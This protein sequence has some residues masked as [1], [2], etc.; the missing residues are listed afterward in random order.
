[1]LSIPML[2][3]VTLCFYL[4][5]YPAALVVAILTTHRHNRFTAL[6]LGPPGWASARTE[7][8]DFMVQG[9]I[10]RGRHIVR[11]GATPSGQI[12]AHFHHPPFFTGQV[13]FLPPNEQCQST[14]GNSTEGNWWFQYSINKY[15]N[16]LLHGTFNTA[17]PLIV[18]WQCNSQY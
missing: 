5:M 16:M 14:E 7:L 17:D 15:C 4:F 6:F 18:Q 9:K 1:M 3:Y 13:P 12:S 11:L 2:V 8:L 10:N